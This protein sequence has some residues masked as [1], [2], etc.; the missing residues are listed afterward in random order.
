[1]LFRS[2]Q[3]DAAINPGNSGGPLL[4]ARGEVIGINTAIIQNAQGIG[5]AIPIDKAQEI[6]QQLVTKGKVEH[7]YLGIQMV[8]ISPEIKQ[9]FQEQAGWMPKA[10]KGVLI[11]RVMPNSPADQAGLRAGDA[12]E[13]IDGKPV[14]DPSQ[15]Q[16]AVEKVAVGDNLPLTLERQAGQATVQ[17]QVGALPAHREDTE[18]NP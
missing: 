4:N 2:I 11:V 15:V 3:T 9:Q 10:D 6:A 8:G 12:I 16:E 7:P 18:P 5:F 17:I 13:A 14:T 1:M